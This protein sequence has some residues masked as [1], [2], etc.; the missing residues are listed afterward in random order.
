MEAGVSLMD[1][2][3]WPHEM[4]WFEWLQSSKQT[5]QPEGLSKDQLFSSHGGLSENFGELYLFRFY[6]AECTHKFHTD[7]IVCHNARLKNS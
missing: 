2:L 5:Q 6:N 1:I 3:L 4:E 7:R